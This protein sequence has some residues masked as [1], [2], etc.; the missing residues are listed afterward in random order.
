MAPA[1]RADHSVQS[2]CL[3]PSPLL[4]SQLWGQGLCVTRQRVRPCSQRGPGVEQTLL[5]CQM[6]EEVMYLKKNEG[7]FPP[8][9]CSSGVLTL[10]AGASE[11]GASWVPL[12]RRDLD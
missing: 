9:L 2:W 5:K 4:V 6:K 12:S 3:C 7:T 11:V 10:G 8:T 1:L